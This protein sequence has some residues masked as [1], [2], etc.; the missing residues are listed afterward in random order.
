MRFSRQDHLV[1]LDIGASAIK[2]A[3]IQISKKGNILKKFG[4]IPVVPG[5]IVDGRIM[6]MPEV[7]NTIRSLFKSLKI[8]EKKVAISTGGQTVVIKTINTAKMPEKIFKSHCGRGGAI[9]PL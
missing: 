7:A 8:R 5:A 3:E 4:M 9:Y 6:D 1:G 2:A